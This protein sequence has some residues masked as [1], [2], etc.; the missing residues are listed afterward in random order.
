MQRQRTTNGVAALRPASAGN[1]VI[2]KRAAV[3]RYL[4]DDPQLANLVPDI[5]RAARHQLGP[6]VEL[7]LELYQDP[8]IDD[9]YL[10][11][12]VRQNPYEAS[13]KD[14]I[15]AMREALAHILDRVAGRLLIT[16]DFCP[17]RRGHGNA[18]QRVRA[19]GRSTQTT[20]GRS[21]KR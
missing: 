15:D 10:T 19:T 1:I 20:L 13:I 8:E 17:P 14:R 3:L 16:T 5:C 21:S 11:L 6:E 2:P 9:R 4:K 18:A 7:S 12:Y